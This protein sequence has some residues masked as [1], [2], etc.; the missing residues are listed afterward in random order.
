[1]MRPFP[2]SYPPNSISS[3]P[4]AHWLSPRRSLLALTP[5]EG[6]SAGLGKEPVMVYFG[7]GGKQERE[8]KSRL[9]LL[10][11]SEHLHAQSGRMNPRKPMVSQPL[12]LEIAQ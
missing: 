9:C 1:M 12:F 6:L 3:S 2:H 7:N 5:A 8:G 4:S 11:L 10:H